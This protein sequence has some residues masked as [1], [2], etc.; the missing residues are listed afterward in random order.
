M[1]VT[2]YGYSLREL[3]KARLR[4]REEAYDM[5]IRSAAEGKTYS[6]APDPWYPELLYM[7]GLLY[8]QRGMDAAA[9]AAYREVSILFPASPWAT[10]SLEALENLTSELSTL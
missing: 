8:Q 10:K 1:D 3:I 5:A 2:T 4:Y 9:N 7:V 6:N